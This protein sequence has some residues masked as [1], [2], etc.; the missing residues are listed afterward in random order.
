MA[1]K[2]DLVISAYKPKNS[3]R[4]ELANKA[5]TEETAWLFVRQHLEKMNPV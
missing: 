1:V 2:Q 3:F 4:N 5:G